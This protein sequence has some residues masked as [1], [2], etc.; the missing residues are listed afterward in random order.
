VGG[1]TNE[2]W[3]WFLA[4]LHE[5]LGGVKPVVM[6]NL[7]NGLLAGVPAVFGKKNHAYCVRHVME[8]FMAQATKLGIRRNASKNMLKKRL[9]YT[10]TKVEYDGALEELRKFKRLLAE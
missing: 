6:S 7:G 3:L 1:E 9:A 8:N 4:Q 5:C 10:M 2:D